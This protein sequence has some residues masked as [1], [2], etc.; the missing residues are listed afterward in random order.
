MS[1]ID[2]YTARIRKEAD[3]EYTRQT[4]RMRVLL[5]IEAL[6]T[7]IVMYVVFR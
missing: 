2:N 4:R 1:F 5:A 7:V 6:L 3:E